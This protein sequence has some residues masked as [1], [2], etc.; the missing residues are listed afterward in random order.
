MTF[1]HL[2]FIPP[3]VAQ[4]F[5]RGQATRGI[6]LALAATAGA[7]IPILLHGW[8]SAQAFAQ[9]GQPPA[10]L[11]SRIDEMPRP[12]FDGSIP[13][14]TWLAFQFTR[15]ARF[16]SEPILIVTLIGAVLS[17]VRGLR[18]WRLERNS[19]ADR[20]DDPVDLTLPLLAGGALILVVM[21]RHTSDGW[22]GGDGQVPFLM[23]LAPGAAAA[24][25][26]VLD[27][28][29][30]PLLRLR[31][32]LAPL[33]VA[34]SLLCLP[35]LNRANAIRRPWRDPGP[36]DGIARTSG[37]AIALPSTLG[38]EIAEVIPP[39]D[40]A[41]YPSALGL[42][43]AHIY[44]AWRALTPV[45]PEDPVS[46]NLGNARL[47]ASDRD[48]WLLIATSGPEAVVQA[49]EALHAFVAERLPSVAGE[50]D[51]EREHWRAWR[52]PR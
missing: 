35:A 1:F 50:P 25:G 39:G 51:V 7:L 4:A 19:R 3:L 32:E 48:A 17:A 8:L 21:Y 15:A 13:F 40:V 46:V 12:L 20:A 30:A 37:P 47:A 5:L 49:G 45:D 18:S 16:L 34:T 9:I 11:A 36:R 33:V 31:G 52:L 14:G 38:R 42:T 44:Y 28:L 26:L 10:L 41:I 6:R 29:S 27:S 24:C 23:H 2:F 43:P 22:D